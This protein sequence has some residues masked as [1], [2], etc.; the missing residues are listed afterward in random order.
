[1]KKILFL[2]TGGTIAC[3]KTSEGLTPNFSSE[4]LL[5]HIPSVREKCIVAAEQPFSLDSTNMSPREWTALAETIRSRYDEFDGFV[6]AHGTDTMAYAAAALSC[7][8]QN[9]RKPIMI[10]GSQHPM[11]APESDAPR[12]LRDAF[13]CALDERLHGV[14]VVF[15]GRIIDGRCAEKVDTNDYDAFRSIN[16]G[17]IGGVS[18]DGIITAECADYVGEPVFYDKMDTRISAAKLIPGVPLKVCADG[19]RAVIIEGFGTGGFPDYGAAETSREVSRLAADG[20]YVIM[21][22]QV[23]SG[24]T[25]LS[26]YKVGSAVHGVLEAGKMTRGMCAMKTMWALAYSGDRSEFEKLFN[27]Q[28]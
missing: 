27:G 5:S 20:I 28:I 1:M 13:L 3:E 22:T 17:D 26:R 11:S 25:E 9:S 7:L 23:T 6:I 12:N 4:E 2:A 19:A 14:C 18:A 8:V 24:G 10:T 16:R 15:G 21:T